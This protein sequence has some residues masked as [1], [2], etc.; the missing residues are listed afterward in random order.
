MG[1][2]PHLD[3]EID[4][5]LLDAK[6][7]CETVLLGRLGEDPIIHK[8]AENVLSAIQDWFDARDAELA[9]QTE[10]RAAHDDG[11]RKP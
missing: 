6:Q 5:Q 3:D 2:D 11:E 1:F 7:A 8:L 4:Q 10:G 9:A